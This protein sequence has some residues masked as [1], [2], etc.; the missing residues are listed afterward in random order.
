MLPKSFDDITVSDLDALVV[1]NVEEGQ[2]LDFKQDLPLQNRDDRKEFLADVVSFANTDGGDLLIGVIERREGSEKL[3]TAAEIRGVDGSVDQKI[4]AIE[5][6]IRSAVAPRLSGVRMRA[7]TL[8]NG[9]H[10]LILRVPKSWSGPHM[11]TL[12]ES[13]FYGRSSRGKF[14]LDVHQ[15]RSQFLSSSGAAE[16]L[17]Q[18]R[19]DRIGRVLSHTT[20]VMLKSVPISLTHVVPSDAFADRDATDPR[21]FER[22]VRRLSEPFKMSSAV[23][24]FNLDG[25]CISQAS[26][27][28]TRCYVQCFRNGIFEFADATYLPKGTPG[29]DNSVDTQRFEQA[30]IREVHAALDVFHAMTLTPPISI[31]VTI[32]GVK[33]WLLD[34]F[35]EDAEVHF[36]F[37]RDVLPLTEVILDGP[38]DEFV[39]PL[40]AT[41]DSFWQAAGARETRSYRDGVWVGWKRD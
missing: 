36:T 16:K 27:D 40:K 5:S 1:G 28:A 15:I 14:G 30:V 34:Y 39:P 38:D 35:D 20:P 3:G 4:L 18:F 6:L 33:G 19:D 29:F 25:F 32:I 41:F 10:V 37:D 8:P 12:G 13:R 7:V 22:F 26:N 9:R 31:L 11:I 21:E 23:S 24:R 17:R 2:T